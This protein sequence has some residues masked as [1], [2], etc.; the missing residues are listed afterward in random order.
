MLKE[1]DR[2]VIESSEE[3]TDTIKY[4]I[5]TV[6]LDKK[7]YEYLKLITIDINQV[8]R[9]FDEQFGKPEDEDEHKLNIDALEK[10]FSVHVTAVELDLKGGKTNKSRARKTKKSKR[11]KSKR[12][13]KKNK[14]SKNKRTRRHK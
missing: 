5:D 9:T 4:I 12:N 1:D 8:N 3:P 11:T 2:T 14:K 10:L 7:L 13:N 6:N